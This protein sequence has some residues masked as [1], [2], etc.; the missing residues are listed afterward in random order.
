MSLRMWVFVI[1]ELERLY[2]LYQTRPRMLYLLLLIS[3][4][5]FIVA[6][7][8]CPCLYLFHNHFMRKGYLESMPST[9]SSPCT[10]CKEVRP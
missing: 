9:T 6:V 3:F 1:L 10:K 4:A 2:I 5:A 7:C 8:C